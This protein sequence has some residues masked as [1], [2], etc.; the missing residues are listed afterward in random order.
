LPVALGLVAM[1]K[2]SYPSNTRQLFHEQVSAV[3]LHDY[4]GAIAVHSS[5]LNVVLHDQSQ[6]KI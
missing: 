6:I 1:G 4:N 5:L 2:A 3:G